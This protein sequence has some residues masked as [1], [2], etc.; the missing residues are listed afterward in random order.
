[1]ARIA[2]GQRAKALGVELDDLADLVRLWDGNECAPVQERLRAMVHEER[3]ATRQ[4]LTELTQLASDQC[5]G[6]LHRRGRLRS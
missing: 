4:R 1:M 6:R 3:T 2:F 5:R